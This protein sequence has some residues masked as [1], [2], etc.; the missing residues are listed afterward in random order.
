MRLKLELQAHSRLLSCM[1][2][3]PSRDIFVTAAEDATCNV[4]TL[5]LTDSDQVCIPATHQLIFTSQMSCSLT[6][7]HV[8]LH[9]QMSALLSVCW[10]NMAITGAV[11]TGDDD[12]D[13]CLVAAI[14]Y[15][16][17]TL[18]LWRLP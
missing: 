15:D 11:F 3:H 5:P 1:A 13:D 10:N 4:W 18:Q 12:S 6:L 8:L 17:D 9:V 16:A 14:A 7:R 2:I